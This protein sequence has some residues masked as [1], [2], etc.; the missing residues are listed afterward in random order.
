LT[1]DLYLDFNHD[2]T[3]DLDLNLDL[4]HESIAT[5]GPRPWSRHSID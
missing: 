5:H 1:I 3:L 2:F 4:D